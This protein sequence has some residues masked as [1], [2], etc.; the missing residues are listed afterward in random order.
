M[1]TTQPKL[2]AIKDRIGVLL[3]TISVANNYRTDYDRITYWQEVD[4]EYGKNH[5]T[6]RDTSSDIEHVNEQFLRSQSFEVEGII[7]SSTP[8]DDGINAVADIIEVLGTD[9]SLSQKGTK[10]Q[11]NATDKDI[12]TVGKTRC[13]FKVDFTVMY[14]TG[15]FLT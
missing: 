14:R 9:E 5:L 6:Y 3:G 10:I 15:R 4:T 8:G 13:N 7:Y 11:M 2:K 1:S 12:S